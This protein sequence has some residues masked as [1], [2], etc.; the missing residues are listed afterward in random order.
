MVGSGMAASD[1]RIGVTQEGAE[2]L[3]Q[4]AYRAIRKDIIRGTR[5]PGERLRIERLRQL[6]DIGPTPIREAL[7]KLSAER[8]VLAEGNRGFMVAPL[9]FN[10]FMDMN[11]ARTE[12]ELA[13]LKRSIALGDDAWESRVVA[14]SYIM[15]KED[16]ALEAS[17]GAVPD[18]WEEA[19][20]AFHTALVSACG[21]RW[22]L[23][24]RGSLQDL[25]ERYR[26]ASVRQHRGSRPLVAEHAAI[27]EAVL[28]RDVARASEL[29][30]RHFELTARDLSPLS[31]A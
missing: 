9:D 18:S 21:S 24:V 3:T 2:T 23:R 26:R 25:C 10:E 31:E 16:S 20:A 4:I 6:Y 11:L 17:R 1:E 12:I 27:S 29:L 8:L 5:A 14:A 7:Q 15:A 30:T 22:L 28:A 19:N 13:A